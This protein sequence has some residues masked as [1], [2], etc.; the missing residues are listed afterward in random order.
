MKLSTYSWLAVAVAV[1]VA[2]IGWLGLAGWMAVLV[3]LASIAMHVAGNAIGTRLR[4]DTDRGLDARGREPF[5]RS[6]VPEHSPTLLERSESLG[7]LVPVS[8][9][10]GGLT[11]GLIGGAA[12]ALLVKSSIAGTVLGGVSSA[13]IGGLLGFLLAGF[14]EIIRTSIADA[15]AAE[16]A[17][18]TP[19][20]AARIASTKPTDLVRYQVGDFPP[21]GDQRP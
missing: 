16:K 5:H 4:D 17:A 3:L 14:V 2:A 20:D 6:T 15:I 21:A 10:I 9:A 8:A 18:A 12:L 1:S 11:G 7:R 13:V 19:L